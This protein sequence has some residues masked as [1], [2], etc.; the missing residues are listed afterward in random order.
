MRP[1]HRTVLLVL[2]FQTAFACSWDY[3]IWI[4]RSPSADPLYQFV[5]K[6]KAG[7][8]DQT[9]KIVIP[10]TLNHYGNWGGEFHNGLLEIGVSDEVYIDTTGKRVINIGLYRGWDF[11]DGL[12]A[13]TSHDGGKWGYIDR[14]GKFVIA[15]QFHWSS[16]DY[17]WPFENGLAQVMVSGKVGYI[18]HSGR[19]VIA[20]RFLEG[21][22]F[23]D[24][25][26]RVIVEGPCTYVNREHP[27][28]DSVV[29]PMGTNSKGSLPS[30]KFTFIDR[31]G[32]TITKQRFDDARDF[33]EGLAPVRM[34]NLWGYIDKTG[35]MVIPPNFHAAEPF[36]EGLAVVFDGKHYGY[37]DRTGS[38]V[39]RPQFHRAESF[40]DGRAVVFNN[41]Q[42]SCWYID[43]AGKQVIPGRF[44]VGSS[45]F[46]GL[47]HV[48]LMPTGNEE[49]LSQWTGTFA[50]IDRSGRRVFI[51]RNEE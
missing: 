51:Y 24:G 46:K 19:F 22:S 31:S 45:F 6:G 20:P 44:H 30:C 4:S 38:Y 50:Y 36:A 42:V 12:A 32:R 13:A 5:I 48:K 43:H 28:P 2:V 40:S 39:I 11:S 15:P 7:Y 18:D 35:S 34:G 41:P 49:P 14:T 9:G 27:C 47:A 16:K 26:A 3:S 23:Q 37:I 21:K 29:L 10:P 1:V 25:I 33:A 8:I 17:V